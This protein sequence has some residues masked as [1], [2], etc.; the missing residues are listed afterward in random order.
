MEVSSLYPE[1]LAEYGAIHLD[2]SWVR[3]FSM[4]NCRS[5]PFKEDAAWPL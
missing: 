5:R 2:G 4:L 1:I 3:D